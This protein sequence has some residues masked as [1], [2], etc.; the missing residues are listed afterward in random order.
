MKSQN[1]YMKSF[2]K[3][4]GTELTELSLMQ[5]MDSQKLNELGTASNEVMFLRYFPPLE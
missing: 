3:A 5:F 1:E 2:Y 4:V